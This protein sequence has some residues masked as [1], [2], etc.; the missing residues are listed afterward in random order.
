M[1]R[2]LQPPA[3]PLPTVDKDAA[4]CW[5]LSDAAVRWEWCRVYHQDEYAADGATFR[6]FGPQARFDHHHAADPPQI[7]ASGRRILYVGEDLAT[8]TCEVFGAAGVATICPA[9]RVSILVPTTPLT[10]YDIVA[11]GA[12]MA[13]GAVPALGDGDEPRSLTQEWA[14]AIYEDQP[15]AKDVVGIHYRSAYNSG[16]SLALWDCDACITIA[17][18]SAGQKQDIALND[19]RILGRLQTELKRRQIN[20]TTVAAD[21]CNKCK[22]APPK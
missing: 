6:Q 7:D 2:R 18:D 4:W 16:E 15:G 22:P 13:I 9:Y 12:A 11:K 19:H 14:R 5:E 21:N 1:I 3:R 8:S 20:V 17:T 10:V